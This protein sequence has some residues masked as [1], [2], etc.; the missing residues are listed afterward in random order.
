MEVEPLE[1]PHLFWS[2][3]QPIFQRCNPTRTCAATVAGNLVAQ[4]MIE[5]HISREKFLSDMAD[6]YD[7]HK[8]AFEEGGPG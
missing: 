2:L 6:T 4:L 3:L 1:D 5:E 7:A 8:K